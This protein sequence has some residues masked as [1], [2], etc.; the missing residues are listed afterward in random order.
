M[1][2]RYV[3]ATQL[4]FSVRRALDEKSGESMVLVHRTSNGEIETRNLPLEV[5]LTV[6]CSI[7]HSLVLAST[8]HL[9]Q[10]EWIGDDCCWDERLRSSE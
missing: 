4:G 1:S 6:S 7:C 5:V 10:N 9:H 8:A 2:L 3:D